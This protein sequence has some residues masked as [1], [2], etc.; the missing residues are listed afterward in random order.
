[1]DG[2]ARGRCARGRGAR[3]RGGRA[4]DRGGRG[5]GR[6]LSADSGESAALRVVTASATQS[7][8]SEA[9]LDASVSVGAGV[10]PGGGAAPA[11]GRDD[12]VV[13]LMTQLLA[14]ILVQ[15]QAVGLMVPSYW[16]CWGTCRGL[17]PVL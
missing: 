12:L 16:I 10:A 4:R 13:G 1:M 9:S 3:D 15:P 7:M 2:V 14:R 5:R 8:A 11:H 17:V 6:E